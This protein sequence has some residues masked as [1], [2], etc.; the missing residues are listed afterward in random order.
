MKADRRRAAAAARDLLAVQRWALPP[1]DPFEIARRLQVPIDVVDTTDFSGCLMRRGE[2]FGIFY[3]SAIDNDGFRRF[4]VSH[5]LGHRELRHHHHHLFDVDGLHSSRSDFVSDDWFEQEADA[6]AVELL[7]PEERFR[8][9]MRKQGIGL[10][11]IKHFA[12]VFQTSLTSTAIRYAELTGDPVIVM[13]SKGTK[14]L[15][16]FRSECVYRSRIGYLPKQATV[17]VKS[18]TGKLLRS[19]SPS[20]RQRE[21][22]SFLSAW[23]DGAEDREFNEDVVELGRYGRTLTVLHALQL[24]DRDPDGHQDD[25]DAP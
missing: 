3:S 10:P 21:G 2:K 12:A 23:F 1:V 20:N 18:E 5:E 11:A 22:V 24:P 4:T 15:Y 7:M 14:I 16:H 25:D 17:P 8:V 19:G 6:F 9:E 13:V